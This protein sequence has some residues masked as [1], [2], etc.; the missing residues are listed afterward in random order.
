MTSPSPELSALTPES[1]LLYDGECPACRSYV[2]FSRLR[3]LYPDLALRDARQAPDLVAALRRAGYEINE[4]MV[5][6]LGADIHFGPEATR[7]IAELGR[8][9]PS[10]LTRLGLKAIGGAPWSRALYPW[11]NRARQLLLRLLGRKLIG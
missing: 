9:A 11:L 4:G 8:T 3:R 10:P 6:K 2:A 1:F 7:M 5:L